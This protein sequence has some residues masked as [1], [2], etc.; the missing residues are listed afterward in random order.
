MLQFVFILRHD[1]SHKICRF[2]IDIFVVYNH[3]PNILAQVISNSSD[4]NVAFL[5]NQERGGSRFRGLPNR[6][7]KVD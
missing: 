6:F 4:D 3:F 1:L 7:P 2:L 5:V